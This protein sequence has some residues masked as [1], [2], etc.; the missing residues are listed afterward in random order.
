VMLLEAALGFFFFETA[1]IMSM[2][3]AGILTPSWSL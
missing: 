2:V 1:Y 3:T